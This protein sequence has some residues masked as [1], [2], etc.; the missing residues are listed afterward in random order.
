MCIYYKYTHTFLKIVNL[1]TC[2]LTYLLGSAYHTPF[3]KIL[4]LLRHKRNILWNKLVV[5]LVLNP[6]C[7]S[8]VVRVW[9]GETTI[10]NLIKLQKSILLFLWIYYVRLFVYSQSLSFGLHGRVIDRFL[11]RLQKWYCMLYF[12]LATTS[13]VTDNSNTPKNQP[14]FWHNP[15][16]CLCQMWM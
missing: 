13:V 6:K 2:V 12:F 10:H 15:C 9:E 14:Q 5:V 8:T 11:T 16:Y 1:G 7:S 3:Y 4:L